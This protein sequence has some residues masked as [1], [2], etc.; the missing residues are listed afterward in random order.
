MAASGCARLGTF[1]SKPPQYLPMKTNQFPPD[2][3]AE[4]LAH[5]RQQV[6]RRAAQVC[7]QNG[8]AEAVVSPYRINPLGAHV[9]HQGGP[10][11]ARTI[12]E[13][14]VLVFWPNAASERVVLHAQLVA[15]ETPLEI[16]LKDIATAS[17][18]ASTGWQRYAMA[19]FKVLAA[20]TRLTCGFVGYVSGTMVGAGLS[21][22]ASVV[23]AYLMA[24]AT[25]N[26]ISL[27]DA[28]LIELSRQVENDYL[29][30]RNGVQDQMSITFGHQNGLIRLAVDQRTAELIPDPPSVQDVAWV[31]C[32]SG[33]TREL[34][35]SGFNTRVDECRAAA[36]LLDSTASR[37]CDVAENNPQRLAG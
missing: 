11:L 18:M 4:S 22:S 14:T 32:H 25:A 12:N 3:V 28:E 19:A 27:S 33:Y 29:G 24:L 16:S 30:L 5:L 34:V 1:T 37:L 23:L 7:A 17:P 36:A 9:D 13:Y 21:S 10:V 31:L 2:S 6:V 8:P 15:A 20:H 26:K 35:N